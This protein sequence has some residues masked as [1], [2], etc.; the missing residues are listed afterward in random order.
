METLHPLVPHQSLDNQIKC[1]MAIYYII[2]SLFDDCINR[3]YN[4]MN[5]SDRGLVQR[6]KDVIRLQDDMILEIESGLTT[7]HGKVCLILEIIIIQSMLTILI[8]GCCNWRRN[9]ITN[10]II[11]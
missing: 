7:L 3:E 2:L 5:T 9:Q 4:P 10:Q 1:M 11:R 6:Q 8:V